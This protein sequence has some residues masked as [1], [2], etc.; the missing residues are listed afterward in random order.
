MTSCVIWNNIDR[1]ADH[2]AKWNK[3]GRK[4]QVPHDLTH[5]WSQSVDLIKVE[6]RRVVTRGW[7]GWREEEMEKNGREVLFVGSKL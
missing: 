1:T 5:M 6:S 3:P 2:Y 7:G 4:R